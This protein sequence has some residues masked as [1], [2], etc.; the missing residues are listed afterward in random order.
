[1]PCGSG[2]SGRCCLTW[3]TYVVDRKI[4]LYVDVGDD[5]VAETFA[6]RPLDLGGNPVSLRHIDFGINLDVGFDDDG[7]TVAACTQ[8]VVGLHSGYV[9]DDVGCLLN[10]FRREGT[11]EKLVDRRKSYLYR[12]HCYEYGDDNGGDGIE[13]A[14]MLPEEV[15]CRDSD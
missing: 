6:E 12:R 15:G 9:H 1:M 8:T 13:D 5:V 2:F 4:W 10:L 7:M 11:L 3:R 14:P